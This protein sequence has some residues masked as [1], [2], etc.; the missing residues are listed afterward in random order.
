MENQNENNNY[1]EQQ[2]VYQP[3]NPPQAS[4][5]H[6]QYIQHTQ[7]GYP[8]HA[9]G[10]Q[11]QQTV[12]PKRKFRNGVKTILTTVTLIRSIL[13][14]ILLILLVTLVSSMI[15]DP[16]LTMP[17]VVENF[18]VIRIE[19]AITD[20]R[21]FGDFG[22]DHQATMDYIRALAANPLDRGIL[23]YMNTPGGTV[24]HSD[25]LYLALMDY[26][27]I[28]G[29]P[30]YAFMAEMCASGGYY[31]SMAADHIMAN[32]ITVTGSLGVI[33]VMID[34][35]GLFEE[36]GVQTVVLDSGEH[37]STG[38]MGTE[39]TP[40]QAAVYQS[41]I[42]EYYNLFVSLIAEGRSMSESRVREL[43]DG[44]IYTAP[45]ALALDLIDEI[46]NWEKAL[47]DFKDLTGAVPYYPSLY[48]EPSLWEGML[49]RLTRTDTMSETEFVLMRL[50]ELPSGVPLAIA[51]ELVQS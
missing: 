10:V 35:S 20:S 24:Y 25:E 13:V 16:S 6:P 44:R 33:T 17:P 3:P 37:K 15:A 26:K 31:I 32:R 40:S 12:R 49:A 5:V 51:M 50:N 45:Q 39:I 36:L 27:E 4:Y 2:N 18:S 38:T 43:A 14:V 46:G 29:R 34:F 11:Y 1:Q 30:V 23:L 48:T 47:S 8:Q 21:G 41:F 28:T 22:Y 19:G 9:A 7:G 42:D